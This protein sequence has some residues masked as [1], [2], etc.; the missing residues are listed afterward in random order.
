MQIY[1]NKRKRFHKK[2]VQL[3]Q[4]WFGTPTWR[5]FHC[6]GTPIWPP[7][8]HVK[9]LY[10]LI[11]QKTTLHVQHAFLYN[12]WPSLHEFDMKM[13]NFMFY[14]GRKQATTNFSFSF[15]T[16]MQSPRNF[17]YIWHFDRIEINARK[18]EKTRV[19]FKSDVFAVVAVVDAKVP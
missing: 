17:A 7:W 3:P 9:T 18:F 16:W 6:F 8:R 12:S 14:G 13:P 5:P 11:K 15:W 4:E 10:R 1:W 2:R 19:Q